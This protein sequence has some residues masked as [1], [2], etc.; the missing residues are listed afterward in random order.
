MNPSSTNTALPKTFPRTRWSVVLAAR[1]ASSD[2]SAAALDAICRA[3]WYPLYTYVRRSG[4]SSHD[5]QDLTQEFFRRLLEKRWLDSADRNKGRL[6]TFLIVALKNFMRNEWRRATTQRRG[7]GQA[8]V[9]FDTAF[10]ES[11]YAADA[12]AALDADAEFDRQ[13][14][15][16]LLNLTV[17]RLQAEFAAAGKPG[18]FEALK[19]C[20]MAGRGA[21]DYPAVARRLGIHEGAARVAVHRLRKRFREVYREEI[22]QTLTDGADVEDELRHLAAALAQG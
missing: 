2:E 8:P 13:W 9:P 7:G 15:M 20:L 21:I 4:Q 22:S 18:D 10:A 16:T 14:A 3:Y 17:A 19:G 11:R 1:R 6:R 5:A 12:A